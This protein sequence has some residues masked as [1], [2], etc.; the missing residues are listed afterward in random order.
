MAT[1]PDLGVDNN[2]SSFNL[3]ELDS[4]FNAPIGVAPGK[5]GTPPPQGR[6]PVAPQLGLT[7]DQEQLAAGATGA[8]AGPAVQA[9][10]EKAFP[11]REKRLQQGV[12]DLRAENELQRMLRNMREEELLRRGVNPSDLNAT[13]QTSGTKWMQNW[14][15]VDKEIAGGVPQ[16]S[17]QYQRMK[18]QGPVTSRLTKRFGPSPVGEPGQPKEPMLERLSRQTREAEAAAAARASATQAAE[19]ATNARLGSAVPGVMSTVAKAAVS[20]Y[21][22]GPLA[23]GAAGLSFYE[24][25]QR[26]L[27]GDRSGAVIAALGGVGAITS[28]VPGLGL[29]GTGLSL[30]SAAADY[31]NKGLKNPEMVTDTRN[32]QMDPMGGLTGYSR[33]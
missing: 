14:A 8:L 23:G 7:A 11:S 28:M 4:I 18:G 30:G 17:A 20:P 1:M 26:F 29:A 33:D 3:G 25:Y 13:S 27:E 2:D 9:T 31:V 22:Q 10:L 16:A 19:A 32:A 21:V 24:A 6:K 15:G 12:K 5:G